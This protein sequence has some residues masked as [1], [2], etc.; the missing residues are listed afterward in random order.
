MR[1][2][3][4]LRSRLVDGD[5]SVAATMRLRRWDLVIQLLPDI[6]AMTVLDLGGTAES[7]VRAPVRP[8][9]VHV[10]N[11]E[12]PPDDLPEW[13]S[14]ETGDACE[15]PVESEKYDLAFSNSVIEHVG[16]HHRR[17]QFA[18]VVRNSAKRYW[19][20]TPYRYFPVEPH[21]L[22]PGFQ[23][24]PA[25]ARIEVARRWPLLHTPSNDKAHAADAVLNTEL[26]GRA[27]MSYYFPDARLHHERMAGMV[28][29]LV[30]VRT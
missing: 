19:V 6:N 29:S 12:T 16:G 17:E 24:L 27:E 4:D 26:L 10:V 14:A 3:H 30:A 22:F 13:I 5:K 25:S 7:W 1:S 9:H 18:E 15:L 11:L 2:V 23:F 20:Q 21:F 8:V 28:K